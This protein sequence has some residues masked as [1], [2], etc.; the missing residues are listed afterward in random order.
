MRPF[1]ID[2]IQAFLASLLSIDGTRQ[3]KSCLKGFKPL[4]RGKAQKG[5]AFF[6][7]IHKLF[8]IT[9]KRQGSKF[10]QHLRGPSWESKS[11]LFGRVTPS[12][13]CLYDT[14]GGTIGLPATGFT[15]RPRMPRHL[16]LRVKLD[17]KGLVTLHPPDAK[18]EES[19]DLASCHHAVQFGRTGCWAR[20]SGI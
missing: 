16:N 6:A 5:L 18:V 9:D 8:S 3:D 19:S 17:A 4:T 1:T 11:A 20:W 15:S 13:Q 12:R 2:K 10:G 14:P 7:T